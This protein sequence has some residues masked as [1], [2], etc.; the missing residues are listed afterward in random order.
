LLINRPARPNIPTNRRRL[1]AVPA[2][3]A[4]N[5]SATDRD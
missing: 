3:R 1:R 4:L 5:L 2:A